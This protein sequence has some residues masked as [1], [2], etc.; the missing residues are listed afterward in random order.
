[1]LF[2][3]FNG[4]IDE[5]RFYNRALS[6]SEIQTI[7]NNYMEKMGSYYNVR[8]YASPEPTTSVGEEGLSHLTPAGTLTSPDH[9]AGGKAYW[10]NISWNSTEPANTSIKFQIATNNDS[11]TW[12][13]TGP[14]G[15][16]T[17]YYT[18]KIGQS[19]YS[20]HDND[21]WY[22]KYKAFL[23]TTNTS[24]P[25]LHDVTITYIVARVVLNTN[26]HAT[27]SSWLIPFN[28][29]TTNTTND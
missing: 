27:N 4:T 1:M 13:F 10:G 20:G 21:K 26:L 6:A 25:T 8:K 17:S 7:Y 29:T 28:I 16:N 3:R 19:I 24:V 15:T 23:A 5:V 9:D 14:D 12:N 11:A 22:I 18:T 2:S